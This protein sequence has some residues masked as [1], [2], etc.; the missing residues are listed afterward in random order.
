MAKRRPRGEGSIFQN[1]QGVW[2][3]Q[4]T[5]PDGKRKAKRSKVQREVRD[6]LQTQ[7]QTVKDN[8]WVSD[9][10]ATLGSFL[11]HYLSDVLKPTVRNSTFVSYE[12]IIRMHVKLGLG[13]VRL[14]RVTPQLVQRLYTEKLEGGLSPRSVQYLHA[15]LHKAFEQA[16]KWSLVPR[17]VTDLVDP[18]SVKRHSPVVWSLDQVK[19]FVEA[20]GSNYHYALYVLALSTGLRQGELLGL[21]IDDLDFV[22]GSLQVRQ[23]LEVVRGSGELRL[24]PPK[25]ERGRRRIQIPG[26]ALDVLKAHV[27]GSKRVTGYVFLSRTGTP[28]LPRNIVR[29]FKAL[30]QVAGVPEIRFHDLRHTCATLHLMAGTNPK[31]VQDILGHSTITLTLDTYS[32]VMPGVQE[33]AA[34]KF[35]KLLG[36]L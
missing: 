23:S 3:A 9:E 12:R 10:S 27:R 32:H 17:N 11:D 4:I 1:G 20:A 28:I 24:S 36:S 2:T 16:V 14:T 31:I 8:V 25:T 7:R 19:Q 18:P 13:D 26:P 33:E 29:E 15:I 34:A 35:G 30:L 5:L 22:N 21:Q 6:W